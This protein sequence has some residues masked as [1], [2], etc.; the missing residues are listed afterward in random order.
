MVAL[1]I[2]DEFNIRNSIENIL[3]ENN[4]LLFN[5]G[6]LTIGINKNFTFEIE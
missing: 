6:E 4:F 2:H 5:S 1:E 3:V